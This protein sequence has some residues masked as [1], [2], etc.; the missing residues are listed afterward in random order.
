[1]TVASRKVTI[2]LDEEL[3]ALVERGRAGA[4]VSRSVYIARAAATFLAQERARQSLGHDRRGYTTHPETPEWVEAVDRLARE[5][6]ADLPW[7]EEAD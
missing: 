6:W 4:G 2:T 3:L 5:S 1:V 7:D